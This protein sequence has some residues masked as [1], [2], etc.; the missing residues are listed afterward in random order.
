MGLSTIIF[1]LQNDSSGYR[2]GETRVR[3]EGGRWKPTL[4]QEMGFAGRGV[5]S[6]LQLWDPV[7]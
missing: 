4:G 2:V 6:A 3:K 1:S 5:G 7:K